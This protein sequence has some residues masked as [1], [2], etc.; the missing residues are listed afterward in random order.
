MRAAR[1]EIR[2]AATRGP[3]ASDAALAVD[4]RAHDRRIAEAPGDLEE[5]AGRRRD[6]HELALRASDGHVDRALRPED[7]AAVLLEE[8]LH[9][10]VLGLLRRELPVVDVGHALLPVEPD[11]PRSRRE[12]VLDGE[13]VRGREFARALAPEK[14]AVRA[15]HDEARDLR[16][17]LAAF[18]R[19]DG[20]GLHRAAVHDARVE[21]YDAILVRD[22]AV[23]DGD[24]VRVELVHVDAD[25]RGVE[26]IVSLDQR[27][28]R[29]LRRL[30]AVRGSHEDVAVRGSSRAG[31]A[32][33]L[34]LQLFFEGGGGEDAGDG[35]RGC[36]LEEAAARSAHED[37]PFRTRNGRV[38]T[39]PIHLPGKSAVTI[40]EIATGRR[41]VVDRN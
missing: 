38:A 24:V 30:D 37:Q 35:G 26:R 29:G 8:P 32:G 27:L 13:A 17:R 18:E 12:E 2:L 11:I 31:Y 6:A 1:D 7:L 19:A 5:E 14:H 9:V 25:D 39:I 16:R 20:A 33:A 3:A 36:G 28:A 23:P 15:V 22:A 41:R 4:A 40:A 34:R 10:R 21:L